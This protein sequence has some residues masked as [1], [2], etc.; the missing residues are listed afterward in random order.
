MI[1]SLDASQFEREIRHQN[2]YI[3]LCSVLS[4]VLLNCGL[5][6]V[7][8]GLWVVDCGLWMVDGDMNLWLKHDLLKS[9]YILFATDSGE[10]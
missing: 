7:G 5:W 9:N 6:I 10:T 1:G 2:L 3:S 8:C 4:I